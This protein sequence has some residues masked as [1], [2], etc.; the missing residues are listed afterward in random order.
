MNWLR[1]LLGLQPSSTYVVQM[2]VHNRHG[3]VVSLYAPITAN[4]LREAEGWKHR[5]EQDNK[6]GYEDAYPVVQVR[7]AA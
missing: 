2:E 5:L 6:W 3:E 7:K 1:R 4:S